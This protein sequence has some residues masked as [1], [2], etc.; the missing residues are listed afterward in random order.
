MMKNIYVRTKFWV[1]EALLN[2]NMSLYE[3]KN[4]KENN[5]I[6]RKV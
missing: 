6:M 5:N 2:E 3:I 1:E 4:N